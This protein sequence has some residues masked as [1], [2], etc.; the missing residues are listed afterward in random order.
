LF[1]F[2]CP[3]PVFSPDVANIPP[4]M[5]H[6][7]PL[8]E[9][10]GHGVSG[11]CL[12]YFGVLF[13]S[14]PFECCGR[15][16][17]LTLVPGVDFCLDA[18]VAPPIFARGPPPFFVISVVRLF[19]QLAFLIGPPPTQK[20][21]LRDARLLVYFIHLL[22]PRH[23]GSLDMSCCLSEC[24]PLYL[25]INLP[26]D[27]QKLFFVHTRRAFY[28]VVTTAEATRE[29]PDLLSCAIPRLMIPPV[30]PYPPVPP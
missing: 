28:A 17:H 12:R 26:L 23:A 13:F 21:V 25:R 30:A 19:H 6:F 3:G 7:S 10:S 9:S 11:G 18:V 27:P 5:P 24:S 15:A 2:F 16:H 22:P 14:V 20:A 1:A 4:L 29:S 8:L